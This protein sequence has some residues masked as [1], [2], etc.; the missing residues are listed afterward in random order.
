M[1]A[2][3]EEKVRK[4]SEVDTVWFLSVCMCVFSPVEKDIYDKIRK[5]EIIRLASVNRI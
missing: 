5:A 3:Q 2:A 1:K 4:I